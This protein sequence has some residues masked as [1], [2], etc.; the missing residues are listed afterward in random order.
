MK[1][2]SI[3]LEFIGLIIGCIVMAIGIN[4]FLKPNNIAPGGFSGLAVIVSNATGIQTSVIMLALGL[5]L[6]LFSVKILGKKD[7]LKTLMGLIILSIALT[8]TDSLS[9]ISV[10]DDVL[11]SSLFGALLL[12]GGL[13]IVFRVDGSTGGTDLIALILHRAIPVVS[14]GNFLIVIDGCV[15]ILSGILN[16]NIETALYSAI[17]LYVIVKVVDAIIEGFDYSKAFMIITS[18]EKE[19]RDEIVN[20][21]KRGITIIDARGG[22]TNDQKSILLVVVKRNQEVHLKKLVKSIDPL[23]FTVVSDV[24]EVLGE[25]FKEH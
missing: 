23:A 24:H 8:A 2:R 6:L 11:L 17:A 1:N 19:I 12:G 10:T 22:F 15:V 13:G 16:K 14:V 25:G 9:Q 20:E 3:I 5:P 18:K 21:V 7:T 4:M